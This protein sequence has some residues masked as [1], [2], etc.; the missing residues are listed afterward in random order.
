MTMRNRLILALSAF[1]ALALLATFTLDGMF[2]NALY[3]L[4]M[5]LAVKT[6]IAYKAR[7]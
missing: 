1:A 2:R 6:I 5:G 4:L 7:W 3:I